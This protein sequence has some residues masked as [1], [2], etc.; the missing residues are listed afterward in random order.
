MHFNYRD[1]KISNVSEKFRALFVVVVLLYIFFELGAYHVAAMNSMHK[2]ES[3][4]V[5]GGS[6][7]ILDCDH[8]IILM[9]GL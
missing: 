2:H 3:R 8:A 9:Y 6:L 5:D 1:K 7:I 4:G